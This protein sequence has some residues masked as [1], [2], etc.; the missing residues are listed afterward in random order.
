MRRRLITSLASTPALVVFL[1]VSA[2]D[3]ARAEGK[4]PEPSVANGVEP[5]VVDEP[6]FPAPLPR[7]R[8]RIWSGGFFAPPADVGDVDLG[9]IRSE[10]RVRARLPVNDTASI[11]VTGDFRASH[12]DT[13]GRG[14]LFADCADCPTPGNLYSALLAVQAG[15]LLNREWHFLRDDEQWAIL[16][17]FYGRARWEPGAF[18][19]AVTPGLSIGL[20]YQLPGKLRIALAARIERALDGDGIKVGPTGYLRWDITRKTRLRSRGLGLQLE[21]RP[22]SRVEVFGAVFQSSDRFRL[23]DRPELSSG[24]TFT[25]RQVIVGGGLVFKIAREFRV[26]FETGAIVDRRVT[27]DTRDDDRIDSAD[28]DVS[29]YFA[30]RGEF[31]P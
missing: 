27:I 18:D 26:T 12:Y 21:H 5:V 14:S 23:D 20:G 19:D 16:G 4:E 25:D 17:A 7:D 31:R 3:P 24:P 28:G 1:A 13:D 11:Q 6:A 2:L 30:L 8:I 9:L 15:Y 29:P 10:L 22:G